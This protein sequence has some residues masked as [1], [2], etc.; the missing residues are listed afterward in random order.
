[1]AGFQS[2]KMFKTVRPV[3]RTRDCALLLADARRGGEGASI[4][5]FI[6]GARE[7]WCGAGSRLAAAGFPVCLRVLGSSAT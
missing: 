5:R 7:F 3:W 4:L 6:A 1:M 2:L